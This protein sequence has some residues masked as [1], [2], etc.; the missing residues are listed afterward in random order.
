MRDAAP[1]LSMLAR[2]AFQKDSLT[3]AWMSEAVDRDIVHIL[4]RHLDGSAA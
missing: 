3:E 1:V 2:D 4:T